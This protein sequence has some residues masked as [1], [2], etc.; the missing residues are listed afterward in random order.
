MPPHHGRK[1]AR[2]ASGCAAQD[3]KKDIRNQT[4]K[5]RRFPEEAAFFVFMTS[6]EEVSLSLAGLAATYSPRA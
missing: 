1:P 5:K 6:K 3:I 4:T 2:G